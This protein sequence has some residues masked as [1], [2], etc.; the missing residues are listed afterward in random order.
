[1][2]SYHRCK[3]LVR[4]AS[5]ASPKLE[6]GMAAIAIAA[7]EGSLLENFSYRR[8]T[9]YSLRADSANQ[10][11]EPAEVIKESLLSKQSAGRLNAIAKPFLSSS[12]CRDAIAVHALSDLSACR[13]Q[14]SMA[15]K[16]SAGDR[17]EDVHLRRAVGGP[18]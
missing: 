4:A 9:V 2:V 3:S 7:R 16:K 12:P 18:P 13:S 15:S 6:I 14:R 1:M 10:L 11:P 17:Y 5:A 8:P